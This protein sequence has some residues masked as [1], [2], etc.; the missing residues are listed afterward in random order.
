MAIAQGSTCGATC[1]SVCL[2]LEKRLAVGKPAILSRIGLAFHFG[3]SVQ[4]YWCLHMQ[5]YAGASPH[6][7]KHPL[8][9]GMTKY[10]AIVLNEQFGC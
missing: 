5:L 2:H 1:K 3:Q 7:C 9:H 4:L 6:L 10:A 8:R